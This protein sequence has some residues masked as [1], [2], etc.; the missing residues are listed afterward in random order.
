MIRGLNFQS[1]PE[2]LSWAKHALTLG[3]F[4]I[5]IILKF[6][7]TS[8]DKNYWPK[9][10]LTGFSPQIDQIF[11]TEISKRYLKA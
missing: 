1:V 8:E 11:S 4:W 3:E 6:C 9:C 7:W 5:Q 10:E 2:T